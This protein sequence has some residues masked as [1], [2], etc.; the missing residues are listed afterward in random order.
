[1]EE[2]K[3]AVQVDYRKVF[4]EIWKRKKIYFIVVPTIIVLS[5]LYIICIPR[6]YTT[7][8]EIIPETSNDAMTGGSSTLSS[9]ASTFGFDMSAMKSEDAI[10]PLMYPDL[11]NDNGFIIQ[12]LKI[13]VSNS[14]NTLHT[15]YF[16]YLYKHQKAP[17][18]EKMI[19]SIKYM[20]SSKNKEEAKDYNIKDP[21]HISRKQNKLVE[22]VR[23]NVS[24]KV[25]KKTG[26]ITIGVTDQDP[27]IC[28]T[29]ADSVRGQLE[30]FIINYRTKKV[31]E[32]YEYYKKLTE[33]AH[34]D[35]QK[36]R[37]LYGSFA[38][39]DEEV[40]LE[41]YRQKQEELE[42]EMQLKYNTYTT[43]S[44]QME[45]ARAKVLAKTP[46]FTLVKGAA[47]P[48]KPDG[49]KRLFFVLVWTILAFIG[50]SLYV[51]RNILLPQNE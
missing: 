47:V 3:T 14:E 6:T 40:I 42:N 43:M 48:V 24:I 13:K 38:D 5:S 33:E 17:W 16:T 29:V 11:M 4:S 18:W 41:S 25:D 45:A 21:Y 31:R 28:K 46:A 36:Q 20:M 44:H 50:T 35:Y 1:M 51:L 22:K 49:P 8:T 12:M 23:Q 34:K 37:Q 2:N 7:D 39:A 9:L 26:S 19:N 30:R 27:L 15:D 32:D 10:T